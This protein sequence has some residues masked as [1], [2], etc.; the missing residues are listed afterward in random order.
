ML[1]DGQ[2]I[3]FLDYMI[4]CKNNLQPQ[5]A[6]DSQAS[7]SNWVQTCFEHLYALPLTVLGFSLRA[8]N[9]I[10]RPLLSCMFT[11]WTVTY[12]ADTLCSNLPD[13]GA[14]EKCELELGA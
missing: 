7:E 8:G 9:D 10:S 3:C 1:L 11:G 14:K 4:M 13:D 6:G 12:V 2:S 5:T